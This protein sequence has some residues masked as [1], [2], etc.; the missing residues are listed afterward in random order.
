MLRADDS[1]E[2]YEWLK[3]NAT[4]TGAKNPYDDIW[5]GFDFDAVP[6]PEPPLFNPL[7]RDMSVE[8]RNELLHT[9]AAALNELEDGG[10]SPWWIDVPDRDV[11]RV[12][13]ESGIYVDSVLQQP[14]GVFWGDPEEG[15]PGRW[16]VWI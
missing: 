9:I 3:R 8:R 2:L 4:T 6:E 10:E 13:H 14:V 12:G 15:G 1:A 16:T 5:E 7:K 11:P